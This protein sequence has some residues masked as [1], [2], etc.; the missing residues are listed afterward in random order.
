MTL[1]DENSLNSLEQI[2]NNLERQIDIDKKKFEAI[3][4]EIRDLSN[5]FNNSLQSAFIFQ[6]WSILRYTKN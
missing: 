5:S 6:F 4:N 1:R 2:K 3:K